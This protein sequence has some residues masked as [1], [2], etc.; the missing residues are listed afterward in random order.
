MAHLGPSAPGAEMHLVDRDRCIERVAAGRHGRRAI[1]LPKIDDD[2]CRSWPNLRSKCDRISLERQPLSVR[3]ENVELIPV[4][5]CSSRRKDLP[6]A[7]AAHPHGVAASVP[8][9]EV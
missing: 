5:C 4:S 1:E 8:K 6:E 3:P 7:V 9:I 2:R